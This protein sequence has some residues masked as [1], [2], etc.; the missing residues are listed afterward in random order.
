MSKISHTWPS[1]H[2]NILHWTHMDE[3]KG[4]S[5]GFHALLAANIS[6]VLAWLW[7]KSSVKLLASDSA[8]RAWHV[9]NQPHTA[10]IA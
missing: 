6:L 4:S 5:S 3:M 1:Q 2:G 7:L 9:Q 10:F 8:K